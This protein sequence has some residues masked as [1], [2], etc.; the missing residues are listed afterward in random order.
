MSLFDLL[1]KK[2]FCNQIHTWNLEKSLL[3]HLIIW[4]TQL[5]T[6]FGAIWG[7][8]L[9]PYASP[10]WE[11]R[12]KGGGWSEKR[13]IVLHNSKMAP[14]PAKNISDTC[15]VD[16]SRIDVSSLQGGRS[17]NNLFKLK[18]TL[19]QFSCKFESCWLKKR[20]FS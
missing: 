13:K 19:K 9:I 2:F 18:Q 16:E 7:F 20:N 12:G 8:R 3:P 17:S 5:T 11:G 1:L 15:W 14:S 6:K 10:L 4:T